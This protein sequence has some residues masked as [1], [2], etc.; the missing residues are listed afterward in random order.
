M[1]SLILSGGQRTLTVGRYQDDDNRLRVG[2]ETAQKQVAILLDARQENDL[3]TFLLERH[4]QK[5]EGG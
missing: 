3:L 1:H 2:L 5:I 4:A